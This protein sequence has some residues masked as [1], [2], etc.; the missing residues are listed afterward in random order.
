MNFARVRWEDVPAGSLGNPNLSPTGKR[1]VFEYRGEI[2]P[3]L[4]LGSIFCI[5]ERDTFQRKASYR[6]KKAA[7]SDAF[8]II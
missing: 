7:I 5:S 4:S 1:A 3:F 8:A 6:F 2:F